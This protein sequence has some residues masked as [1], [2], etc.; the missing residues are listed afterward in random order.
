MFGAIGRTLRGI[1]S[2]ASLGAAGQA[3]LIGYAQVHVSDA[4]DPE[5]PG[6]TSALDQECGPVYVD[7][8]GYHAT[9]HPNIARSDRKYQRCIGTALDGRTVYVAGGV[10]CTQ[11][12]QNFSQLLVRTRPE[13]LPDMP[14]IGAEGFIRTLGEM[15]PQEQE[16]VRVWHEGRTIVLLE[17]GRS[18]WQR[19][20][21]IERLGQMVDSF[22]NCHHKTTRDYWTTPRMGNPIATRYSADCEGGAPDTRSDPHYPRRRD[23]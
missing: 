8:R 6:E 23:S 18:F 7:K 22:A 2:L 14:V 16:T 5:N 12:I 11:A 19:L 9:A 1:V 4:P 17:G 15:T 10:G 3:N 13:T 21:G 20:A